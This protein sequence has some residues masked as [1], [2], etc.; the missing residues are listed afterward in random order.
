MSRKK[1]I[2]QYFEGYY[3]ELEVDSKGRSKRRLKYDGMYYKFT[4]SGQELMFYKI[5]LCILCVGAIAVYAITALYSTPSSTT[6]PGAISFINIASL[7]YM[8]SGTIYLAAAKDT[9]VERFRTMYFPR[10]KKGIILSALVTGAS[11]IAE[12]VFLILNRGNIY[13]SGELRVLIGNVVILIILFAMYV[14][15]SRLIIVPVKDGPAKPKEH[16]VV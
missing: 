2:D 5:L 13:W 14:F 7:V 16:Y 10:I 8:L 3:R 15:E 12:I 11:L 4:V 1:N 6:Y 9:F